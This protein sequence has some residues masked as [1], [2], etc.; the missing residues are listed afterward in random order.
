MKRCDRRD[1]E[2]RA[3]QWKFLPR[4][5]AIEL[6]TESQIPFGDLCDEILNHVAAKLTK[7]LEAAAVEIGQLVVV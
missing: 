6:M 5:P 4:F 1:T 7:L 3:Q 2:L